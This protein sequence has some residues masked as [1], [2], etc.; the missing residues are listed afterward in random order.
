MGVGQHNDIEA[1]TARRFLGGRGLDHHVTS[2]RGAKT[3]VRTGIAE[4]V[5][6]VLLVR[7][8]IDLEDGNAGLVERA[9]RAQSRCRI[10]GPP[11]EDI[12]LLAGGQHLLHLL[13]LFG[14]IKLVLVD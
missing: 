3:I 8:L 6:L 9:K 4:D 7:E 11:E 10:R 14:L 1:F 5:F 13:I 12:R 2:V